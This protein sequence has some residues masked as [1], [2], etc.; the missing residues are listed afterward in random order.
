MFFKRKRNILVRGEKKY[1]IKIGDFGLS[2]KVE[3]GYYQ[4]KTSSLPFKW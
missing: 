2:R 4:S 1:E 3:S